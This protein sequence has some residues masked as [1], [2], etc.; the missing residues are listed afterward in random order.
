MK[1]FRLTMRQRE[2]VYGYFFILPFVIGFFLFIFAPV[3]QSVILSVNDVTITQ[4]G[5]ETTFIGSENYYFALRVHADFF[6]QLVEVIGLM[7]LN[8][9]WILVFSFFAAL[10]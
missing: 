6:R 8:V 5:F 2:N 9:F 4:T 3:I 1:R 7:L 10:L